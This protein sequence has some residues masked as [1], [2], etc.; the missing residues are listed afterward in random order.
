[1]LLKDK[2]KIIKID[3]SRGFTLLEMLVALSIF[4]VT[5]VTLTSM[6]LFYQKNTETMSNDE[7][8]ANEA[9]S[10]VERVALDIKNSSLVY[11]NSWP[12]TS[13]VTELRLINKEGQTFSYKIDVC[14]NLMTNYCLYLMPIT[15]ANINPEWIQINSD[16]LNLVNSHFFVYP[17]VSPLLDSDDDGIFDTTTQPRVT[18]FFKFSD[19][20]GNRLFPTQTMVS[21][22]LYVR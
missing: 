3:N 19:S 13:E 21:T 1:M 9:R 15:D 7:R 2:I 16:E 8:L 14:L 17:T 4:M 10:I 22:R 20:H 18:L 5:F 6:F 11:S 12:I